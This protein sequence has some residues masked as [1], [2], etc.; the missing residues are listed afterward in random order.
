MLTTRRWHNYIFIKYLW[1]AG[2]V[3]K[4]SVRFIS[5]CSTTTTTTT[6]TNI[7][8]RGKEKKKTDFVSRYKRLYQWHWQSAVA[9][10]PHNVLLQSLLSQIQTDISL[11]TYAG[12]HDNQTRTEPVQSGPPD[13]LVSDL[14]QTHLE[15][16]PDLKLPQQRI[17]SCSELTPKD[18]L[19]TLR[20][21][22][23]Q[24]VHP[25]LINTAA[26]SPSMCT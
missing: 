8:G 7:N 6:I 5:C 18:V 25:L 23:W 17:A 3:G 1:L 13:A 19:L 21:W 11:K 14:F 15:I 4:T 12:G 9:V 22:S 20:I 2:F 24:S 16:N 10:S 26:Q